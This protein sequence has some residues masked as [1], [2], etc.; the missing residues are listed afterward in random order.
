MNEDTRPGRAT[1][2]WRASHIL[3]T[4]VLGVTLALPGST[5]EQLAGELAAGQFSGRETLLQRQAD[6]VRTAYEKGNMEEYLLA[7]LSIHSPDCQNCQDRAACGSELL[8]RL[9]GLNWRTQ[10]Q[11]LKTGG[12]AEVRIQRPLHLQVRWE[13]PLQGGDARTDRLAGQEPGGNGNEESRI[14]ESKS[15]DIRASRRR[16]HPRHWLTLV[17]KCTR[18]QTLL[19]RSSPQRN[20]REHKRPNLHVF[21][22]PQ[23][24]RHPFEES[25]A[26]SSKAEY[27]R[28][29]WRYRL[30][31]PL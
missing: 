8:K 19:Q 18:F 2:T 4:G 3:R 22:L 26:Q 15:A 6:K 14:S 9:E 10:P 23:T 11:S 5:R 12:V 17:D 21:R 28:G 20:T 27:D 1:Y 13:I 30:L 31:S 25:P 16:P 29:V 7:R 24:M